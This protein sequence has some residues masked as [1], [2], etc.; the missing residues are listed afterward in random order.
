MRFH[1]TLAHFFCPVCKSRYHIFLV[2]RRFQRHIDILY[3]RYGEIQHICGL[4]V[5]NLL[6]HGNQLGQI[7][8]P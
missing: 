3:F 7:V 6:K 1:L 4:N 2:F 8:E 5:R